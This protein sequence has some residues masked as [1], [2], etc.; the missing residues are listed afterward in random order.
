M[1]KT[2]LTINPYRNPSGP[3]SWRVEGWFLGERLR[4][5]FRDRADALAEKSILEIRAAQTEAGMRSAGRFLSDP[6]LP[7][8]E[9]AFPLLKDQRPFLRFCVEYTLAHPR[10]PS[11]ENL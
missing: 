10:E 8:V 1:K 2:Q 5:N 11:S 4:K 9:A 7:G 3:Q 6:Q